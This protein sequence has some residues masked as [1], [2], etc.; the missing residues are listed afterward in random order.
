MKKLMFAA[1]AAV[2]VGVSA[3]DAQA[4][5]GSGP[6]APPPGMSMGMPG[7]TAGGAG[8]TECGDRHGWHPVLKKLMWWKKDHGCKGGCAAV[9]PPPG[10][11]GGPQV[12]TLV[13]PNHPF[14]RSPRD[15]FM[16]GQGG[17]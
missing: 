3:A 12:G 2:V 6:M 11:P 5:F 16:Y 14:V 10:A 8:C 7:P 1:A 4:Q 15:F 17:Y 9:P 13:F